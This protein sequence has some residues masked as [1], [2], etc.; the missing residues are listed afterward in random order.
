M[1]PVPVDLALSGRY[2]V[3]VGVTTLKITLP[4]GVFSTD[5]SVCFQFSDPGATPGQRFTVWEWLHATTKK[6]TALAAKK[7]CFDSVILISKVPTRSQPFH[8]P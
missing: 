2:K 4:M 6:T 8:W 7:V 5:F 3:R 1:M